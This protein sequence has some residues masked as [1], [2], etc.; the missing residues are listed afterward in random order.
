MF[1]EEREKELIKLVTD[2][3][4]RAKK[5]LDESKIV[6]KSEEVL[7]EAELPGF[8][9]KPLPFGQF[10][11]KE[12]V[13]LMT[14]IRKSTDI[15]NGVNG[16]EDMFMIFYAYSALVA[17]IVDKHMGT[18]TEFLGDGVLCLFDVDSGRDTALRHALNAS[19]E[20]LYAREHILNRAFEAYSVP[21]ISF[22]IGIDYGQTIVTRFGDKTD[23]DLKAFGK[24][25]YNVSRLSKGN[26][27]T[28]I[29]EDAQAV[30]P[31]SENGTLLFEFQ[32]L[33]TGGRGYKPYNRV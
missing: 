30:W 15:I 13:V 25:V 2:R 12:Y 7:L 18:S 23:N 29:S 6:R 4:I 8:E 22:G 10:I 31:T 24:C 33:A 21:K 19:R 11:S 28:L 5:F 14:D 17:N 32:M 3:L 26:N 20:L 27:Q 16:T 9:N 1:T